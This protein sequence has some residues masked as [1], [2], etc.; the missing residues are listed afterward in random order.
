VGLEIIAAVP[1]AAGTAAQVLTGH[2]RPTSSVSK[3]W[4]HSD[5]IWAGIMSVSVSLGWARGLEPACR[6]CGSWCRARSRMARPRLPGR[7]A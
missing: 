6:R 3:A 4:S 5:R 1:G 2:S 7:S